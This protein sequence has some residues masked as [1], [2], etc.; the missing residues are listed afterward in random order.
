MSMRTTSISDSGSPR[1]T[2]LLGAALALAAL[3]IS[4]AGTAAA[5][6]VRPAQ[7]PNTG[8]GSAPAGLNLLISYTDR[9]V[10]TSSSGAEQLDAPFDGELNLAV[11]GPDGM[12][13]VET[14][15]NG[16]HGVYRIPPGGPAV[17]V[18][19]GEVALTGVGWLGGR[20]AAAV[21]DANGTA[22]PNSPDGYGTVL[23][24]FADGTRIDISEAAGWEWGVNSVAI[25]ADRLVQR[26][27]AEGYEWFAMY[28]SGGEPLDDWSLPKEDQ[29]D[30]PPDR[31]WPV[32]ATTGDSSRPVLSWVESAAPAS[33]Q[34]VVIDPLT[35]AEALRVELGDVGELPVYSDFD[36]RFWVGTFADA[37]DPATG[38]W[39]PARV[40][41]VDTESATP[42][43]IDTGCTSGVIATID[44]LGVPAPV[45]P[46]TTAPPTTEPPTTTAPPTTAPPATTAAPATT[47]PGQCAAYVDTDSAYPVRKCERGYDVRMIQLMLSQRGYDVEIDG[48]FGP[49][50]ERAVRTF[51]RDAGLDP[52]GLVGR[53]T[54]PALYVGYPPGEDLDANGTVD[55]WELLLDCERRGEEIVCAGE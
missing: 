4:A 48:Y 20:S 24:A 6:A 40:I 34:L 12:V 9:V 13:W 44:R 31:W 17:S 18:V 10:A 37:E 28:G 32:P 30:V 22:E 52:D 35:G 27:T 14:T 42:T 51:Q 23:A 38:E 50:T 47:Q 11:R 8:C 46:T 41:A 26:G 3:G 19:E 39:Q 33:W 7:P 15:Q 2:R 43:P 49:S 1:L 53:A 5:S 16:E 36:G 25:G 55:P 54:W 21:I 45:S 29:P